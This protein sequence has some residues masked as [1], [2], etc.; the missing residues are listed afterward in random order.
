MPAKKKTF[1]PRG[2]GRPNKLVIRDYATGSVTVQVETA[3]HMNAT[4]AALIDELIVLLAK[5]SKS[6]AEI[7][8]MKK[9]AHDEIDLMGT[10]PAE[11]AAAKSMFTKAFN[12]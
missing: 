7:A 4:N 12:V 11:A 6:T 1:D 5:P 8:R 3:I 10:P 9:I 2:S